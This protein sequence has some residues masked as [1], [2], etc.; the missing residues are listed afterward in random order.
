M[1][2]H[3]KD[4]KGCL[5]VGEGVT[6]AGQISLPGAIFVDGTVDGTIEA[7]ELFVGASGCVT[8]SAK[9]AKADIRGVMGQHLEAAEHVTLRATGRLEGK[10]VYRS[11]D[12]ERGGIV[13]GEM[14]CEASMPEL[15]VSSDADSSQAAAP[16]DESDLSTD[17]PTAP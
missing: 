9:V 3:T 5:F 2:D 13:Q 14:V 1:I 17:T 12:I 10:I 16:R 7:R 6:V 11:I 15:A 4:T 8:G